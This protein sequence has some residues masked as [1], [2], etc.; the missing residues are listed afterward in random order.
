VIVPGDMGTCSY[1]LVGTETAMRETW[2]ST[3]HGAGRVM[4]RNQALKRIRGDELLQQ[5]RAEGIVVRAES[6][7]TV[8]EEAP[9]AYKDV[10]EVVDSCQGAGISK[11]VAKMR[12]IGVVKG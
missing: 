7:K 12:P 8:A 4:S 6:K 2:G 3:C 10:G 5:L 1:V 11:K 9:F